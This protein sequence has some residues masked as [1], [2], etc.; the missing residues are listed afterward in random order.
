MGIQPDE[1]GGKLQGSKDAEKQI[2]WWRNY[3][4][5]ACVAVSGI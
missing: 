4:V 3:I 2:V 1:V 5:F